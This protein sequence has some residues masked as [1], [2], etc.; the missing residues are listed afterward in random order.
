MKIFAVAGEP[1]GD[2]MLAR[3]LAG[4]RTCYPDLEIAG[5]GG[6]LSTAQG[7]PT[8]SG[9]SR[10]AVNGV[11]DT[12]RQLPFLA[13]AYLELRRNLRRFAPDLVLLVDYPGMN[14]GLA[15]SATAHGYRVHYVGPPQLWAYRR[16]ASRLRRLRRALRGVSLQ[17]LFPFER[18]FY[19]PWA[20][21]LIAGH[22]FAKPPVRV[23]G[24]R[25]LL[26]PG[27]RRTVLR[28]N[29]PLWL[30]ALFSPPNSAALKHFS[31]VDVLSPPHLKAEATRYC[32]D[33]SA[34][35][36]TDFSVAK[37]RAAAALAF[38]GT[39]TL[40]LFL[41]RLPAR[42]WAVLDPITLRAGRR[43]LRHPWTALPN[44]LL[45]KP[46]YAEWVGTPGDFRHHPPKLPAEWQEILELDSAAV[47]QKIG[48]PAGE[49]AGVGVCRELLQ[50]M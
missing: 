2:R 4:L 39:M 31:G 22:F 45:Q 37:N 42:V 6:P 15:R 35:V 25:L 41:H 13:R 30:Q 46:V 23:R 7:L 32:R 47:W 14:V 27:S 24:S 8:T 44:L 16:P 34:E 11:G 10:L 49:S 33:F 17:V 26:C 19:A 18:E 43:V 36:L 38:P 29:L 50:A 48:A 40:E 28:R 12:L 20:Q 5:M 1:S 3:L 9:W 21:H